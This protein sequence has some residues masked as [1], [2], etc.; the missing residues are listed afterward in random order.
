VIGLLL[1]MLRGLLGQAPD[2]QPVERPP[3][4]RIEAAKQQLKETI[5]PPED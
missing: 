4:E 5:P 2:P 1:R 3:A